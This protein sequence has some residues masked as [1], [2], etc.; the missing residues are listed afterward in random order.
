MDFQYKVAVLGP[1]PRDTIIT[2]RGEVVEKYGAIN[3]TVIGL[4]RLLGDNSKIFPVAHMR[5]KDLPAVQKI[6]AQYSNVDFSHIT[7]NDD[8]GD[9]IC[10]RFIDQNQRLE[11]Q[12]G[13]MSPI[14][15]KDVEELVDCDAYVVVPVTEFEIALETLRFL[16]QHNRDAPVIFDAHGP[17]N[18]MTTLGDRLLKFWVDRDRWLP[19]ID[20]LKMN[21]DEAKCCWFHNKYKLK[22]LERDYA[23]T[24]EDLPPF[25]WHCLRMGVRLVCVTLDA[26]GCLIF[27]LNDQGEME[28]K[29]VPAVRVD[30]VIDTTGC[31]DSFAAGLAF[32]VLTSNDYVKAAQYANV[33]GALRTQG[34]TFDVFKDFSETE[35]IRVAAYGESENAE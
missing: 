7:D 30:N 5:K 27:Y 6:L 22:D 9:V 3:H 18:M 28:E 20:V 19:Y 12:S 29:L 34:K 17:T 35:K 16:K 13:I 21:L 8:Q 1:I 23:F 15:I 2:Y 4:S 25:A 32:G 33:L 31:G 11:K 10:L 24:R 14:T 26:E